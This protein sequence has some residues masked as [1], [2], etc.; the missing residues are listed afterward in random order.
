MKKYLFTLLSL[1][2]IVPIMVF[3]DEP[4]V[5]TLNTE[6]SSNAVTFSGT[7]E[8]GS[9]AVM[10]KL[11]DNNN[12]EKDM[13][14]VGV[15]NGAFEGSFEITENGN[16]KVS[17][18][19][20]EGGAIKSDTATATAVIPEAPVTHTITFNTNGGSNVAAI[21]VNHGE[22]ATAPETPEKEGYRFVEW[23]VDETLSTPFDFNEPVTGDVLLYAKWT[24]VEYVVV[25]TINIGEGGTYVVDFYSVGIDNQGPIGEELSSSAMYTLEKGTQMVLWVQVAE[26]FRF[27][28]WYRVHE[29]DTDGH[30]HMEWRLDD[31]V[32]SDTEFRFTPDE[33]I[34]ISPIFESE[35]S[36]VALEL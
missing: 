10:C 17:C 2:L 7:V 26:G 6:V 19:N 18:A 24:Q 3:A 8:S 11:Y 4:R 22:I 32:S 29:E 5:L 25:H 21:T 14:S 1:F 12:H 23:C 13:L 30:G 36:E 9:H 20:Y 28:G 27:D 35:H 31:K 16:Y 15:N 33:N 34:Y